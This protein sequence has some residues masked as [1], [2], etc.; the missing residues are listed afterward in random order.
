MTTEDLATRDVPADADCLFHAWG[1]EVQSL[2]PLQQMPTDLQITSRN[3]AY[4]AQWRGW[5]LNWVCWTSARTS[6][7][8][9]PGLQGQQLNSDSKF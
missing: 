7:C 2:K 8:E 6:C 4:G 5:F 3:R 9:S 1:L